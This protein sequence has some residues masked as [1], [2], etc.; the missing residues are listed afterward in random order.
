MREDG[1]DI[2]GEIGLRRDHRLGAAR[3]D[4]DLVNEEAVLAVDRLVAGAE[5]G[6]REQ[7]EKLVG[8]CA[9]DDARGIETIKLGK[10]LAHGARRAVG[11]ARER[12]RR[13]VISLDSRR[14]GAE[15]RL[16]RGELDDRRNAG[17]HARAGHIGRDVENALTRDRPTLGGHLGALLGRDVARRLS[18]GIS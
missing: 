16:V 12:G 18:W 2:G 13:G 8:A 1:I 5:I 3:E 17:E 7:V 9:A 15:R 4:G 10:S 11:V 6:G 14:G